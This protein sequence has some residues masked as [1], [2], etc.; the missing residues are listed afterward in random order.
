VAEAAQNNNTQAVRLMLQAGWPVDARSQHGA[1]PLHWAAFHGNAEMTRII[2]SHN[3]P[4]ERM[5]DDFHGTPF[6][7]ATHGSEHGWHC[8]TGHY[9]ETV[10]AL[11]KAGATIPEK[12]QG[13]D[14]VKEFLRG[15]TRERNVI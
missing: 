12:I 6:G 3:P 2:L 15:R 10:E 1:T 5:D 9:L 14:A 11:I 7:W 13:T 8:K 4:L